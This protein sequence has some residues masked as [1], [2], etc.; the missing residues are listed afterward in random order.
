VDRAVVKDG[1]DP[2]DSRRPDS[3]RGFPPTGLVRRKTFVKKGIVVAVIAST[4]KRVPTRNRRPGDF[5]RHHFKR[6]S[7]PN[8]SIRSS[9]LPP[10]SIGFWPAT[11]KPGSGHRFGSRGV[12]VAAKD[13]ATI[14]S[15]AN[16]K[17]I[18]AAA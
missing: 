14:F 13:C 6:R 15:I 2:V 12:M 16:N 8:Q 9:R 1:F 7:Q 11:C 17:S 18:V 10:D 5:P 3:S 4:G